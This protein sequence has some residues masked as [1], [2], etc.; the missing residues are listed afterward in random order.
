MICAITMI[1][2]NVCAE[3][4]PSKHTTTI[5]ENPV[6]RQ[7]NVI[8]DRTVFDI[9]SNY[10]NSSLKLKVDKVLPSVFA[11]MQK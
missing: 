1:D 7:K 2:K 4:V 10:L 3:L 8:E 11:Y 6:F 9:H 5:M